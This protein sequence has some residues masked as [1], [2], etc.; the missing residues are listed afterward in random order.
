MISDVRELSQRLTGLA[1]EME[2]HLFAPRSPGSLESV[3]IWDDQ[4]PTPGIPDG[5]LD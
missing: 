4:P 2:L 5:E 1:N 3:D